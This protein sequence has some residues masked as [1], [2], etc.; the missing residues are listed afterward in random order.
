VLLVESPDIAQAIAAESAGLRVAA[1][2]AQEL[3]R[4]LRKSLGRAEGNAFAR[5][6]FADPVSNVEPAS[7]GHRGRWRFPNAWQAGRFCFRQALYF[8]ESCS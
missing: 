1:Q 3:A 8:E 6:S 5:D 7:Y 2:N 4:L